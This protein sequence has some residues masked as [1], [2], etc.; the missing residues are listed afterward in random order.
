MTADDV[1]ICFQKQLVTFMT[2]YTQNK[3]PKKFLLDD[4]FD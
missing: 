3:K 4:K 1:Y 2:N